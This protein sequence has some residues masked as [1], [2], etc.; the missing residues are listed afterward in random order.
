MKKFFNPLAI[1]FALLFVC[2]AS[3]GQVFIPKGSVIGGGGFQFE[4]GKTEYDF[5][6]STGETKFT[7]ITFTPNAV[8]FV[9]DNLGIGATIY[10]STTKTKNGSEST[11]SD[12][13]FSPTV[14]YYFAEGPF[15][16]AMVG[17]GSSK[18]ESGGSEFKDKLFGW[19]F[20]A[21][22]S[23]RISDTVLLDPMIGYGSLKSTDSENDEFSSTR[24][25]FFVRLGF[26]VVLINP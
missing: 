13:L 10:L 3:F 9:T 6:G 8:Y 22:Y 12:I 14:R 2:P 24:G 11:S 15:A 25:G 18:S 21:G 19:E 23:V 16:Q 17:F 7:D 4:S 1:C 5:G 26:T 20:G